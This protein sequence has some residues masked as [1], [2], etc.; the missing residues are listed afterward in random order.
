M[1]GSDNNMKICTKCGAYN[2]NERIFCV[3]CSEKLGDKLSS[4]DEK[5][6]LDSVNEKIE[7]MY[8]KKD[9]LYVSR[10]DKVMGLVSL[11][12]VLCS[13]ILIVIGKITERNF[14]ILWVGVIFFLLASVDAFIPKVTW[15][16]E[17]IRLSFIIQ[18]V[19]NAEP[20][21]FYVLCRKA[22]IVISVLVGISILAVAFLDFKHPPIRKYIADIAA[23]ESVAFSSYTKDYINANPEKWQKIINSGDYTVEIFIS[24]LEEA[25]NTGLEEQLMMD[26]IIEISGKEDISYTNKDDFLFAYKTYGW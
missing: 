5:Q 15:T 22:S 14:A 11:I 6:T 17:K 13:V 2:S 18:D 4:I 26:A 7:E 1:Q 20:S 9:P 24:E 16:I 8:N 21:G 10:V 3:D 25:D 23:T 12:G 19:D